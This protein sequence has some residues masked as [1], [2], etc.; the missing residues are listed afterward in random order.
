MPSSSKN[1]APLARLRFPL[2]CS[3]GRRYPEPAHPYRDEFQRDRDR[4]VHARAFRRLENKTQVFATGLS[5]HFRNRLTHT[6]EV[7][8]IARTVA[9][10]LGL[11]EDFTEALALAHDIGHPPF[12]HAGEA[13][14]DRRMREH[15]D[16]FEHNLHAL[17]IVES[18]ENPYPRFP[19]LNLT[20]EVREGIVKHSSDAAPEEYLPDLRPPLEAQLID[21]CD[22]IAY[23]AADLDDGYG[24]GLIRLD[25]AREV[26]KFRELEGA[27]AMQFPGASERVRAQVV[28]RGLIDWMVTGLIEGTLGAAAEI[29]DLDA[30]R[31]HPSRLVRFTA[32]TAAGSAELKRFL[33]RTVYAS[34]ELE[35]A[36]YQSVARVGAV[37]EAFLRNPKLL[38]ENYLEEFA[39]APPHRLVCDYIAGMTDR[40]L[41]KTADQLFASGRV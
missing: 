15:G 11:D 5:D 3:R 23:N 6:I 8:Q 35:R 33:H 20:F 26:E 19:G 38:P 32:E 21:L 2:E 22:E 14:L 1:S 16:R 34:A 40:F 37:F 10:V 30:V 28:V 13:E 31:R 41:L 7:S 39:G 27:A 24:A 17:R 29:A 12:G 36:R 4:I 18:F 9:R 25:A